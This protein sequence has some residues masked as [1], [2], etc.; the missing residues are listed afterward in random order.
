MI[1]MEVKLEKLD[2]KK[3]IEHLNKKWGKR[4]CPMCGANSWNISE[5]TYELREFKEGPLVVGGSIV[6][7]ILVTCTNCGN[8]VFVNAIVANIVKPEKGDKK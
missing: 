7:I 1:G 2:K 8:S 4:S 5:K 6:P 3:F